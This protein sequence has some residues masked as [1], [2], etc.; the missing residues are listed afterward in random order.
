MGKSLRGPAAYTGLLAIQTAAASCLF[1]VD[2]PIF[3]R[4]VSNIGHPQELETWRL[5]VIAG[6]V[7]VLQSSYW[8][9]LHCV[10]IQ[11]PFENVLVGHL[12]VFASRVSF[13]F[14][15]VFFSVVFFRHLPEFDVMPPIDQILAKALAILAILFSLFCYALELERFGKAIEGKA[16]AN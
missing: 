16:G 4:I 10:P 13:F 14:G 5:V 3:L 15:S 2:L 12:L 1:W 11:V 9:R 6:S 7:A 8:I